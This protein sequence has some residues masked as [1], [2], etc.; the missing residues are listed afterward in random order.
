MS[1]ENVVDYLFS[2]C[3]DLL[4][5]HCHLFFT[6]NVPMNKVIARPALYHSKDIGIVSRKSLAA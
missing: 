2:D 1:V 6:K 3:I 5:L 4:R